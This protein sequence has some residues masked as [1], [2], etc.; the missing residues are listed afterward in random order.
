MLEEKTWSV[1]IIIKRRHSDVSS[2]KQPGLAFSHLQFTRVP[3]NRYLAAELLII[4]N[5]L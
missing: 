3:D 4:Q 2:K 1:I 5:Q